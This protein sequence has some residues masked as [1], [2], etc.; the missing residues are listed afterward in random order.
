MLAGA[1]ADEDEWI[2]P[3]CRTEQNQGPEHLNRNFFLERTLE[4]FMETRKNLCSAHESPKKLRKYK[5]S[6][7]EIIRLREFQN[8]VNAYK[9]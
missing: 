2:C 4:K 5:T 6:N 3:E 9:L 1:D 7:F 8:T